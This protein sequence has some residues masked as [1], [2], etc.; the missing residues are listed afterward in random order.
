MEAWEEIEEETY[1]I[2]TNPWVF[3]SKLVCKMA[4]IR[5]KFPSES[6]LDKKV[7]QA[8]D[9]TWTAPS[10]TEKANRFCALIT[11]Q[12]FIKRVGMKVHYTFW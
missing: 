10:F 9:V 2:K 12:V 5:T 7:D 3:V 11:L 4:A 1:D 8:V 6:I